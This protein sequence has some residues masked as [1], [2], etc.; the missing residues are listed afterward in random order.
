MGMIG[1]YPILKNIK[2]GDYGF[3]SKI[4]GVCSIPMEKNQFYS[5]FFSLGMLGK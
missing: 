5:S 2:A 4:F 1:S 3:F